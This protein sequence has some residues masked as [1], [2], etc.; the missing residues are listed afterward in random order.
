MAVWCA[1]RLIEQPSTAR[2]LAAGLYAGLAGFLGRN[3]MLYAAAA[4]ALLIAWL[5]WKDRAGGEGRRIGAWVLGLVLGY[6]PMWAMF[7][8]VPGFFHGFWYSNVLVLEHGSNLPSPYP[9]PWLTDWS[10]LRGW[11]LA[12]QAGLS[13]AFL[14]PCLAL[15]IGLVRVLRMRKDEIGA[16]A[17][18]A[19]AF[20]VG[21]CYVHHVSVRSHWSH[22]AEC[23]TPTLLLGLALAASPT[24]PRLRSV[25]WGGIALFSALAFLEVHSLFARFKPGEPQELVACEVDGELLRLPVSKAKQLENLKAFFRARVRPE[26]KVFIAPGRPALYSVLAKVAPTWW[27]YFFWTAT[28]E[29]QRAL[30][31]ELATKGVNWVLVV[32]RSIDGVEERRFAST[33]PLVWQHLASD[34][35]PI[36]AEELGPPN[37]LFRRRDR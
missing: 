34:F 26:E 37:V 33:H 13:A 6:S 17:V 12:C 8:F 23:L 14:L 7:L 9:W 18:L 27:I 19:A 16:N 11:D 4:S 28:D 1:V 32:D 22:L 3:H 30:I 35:T 25:V 29:E 36:A 20:A 2:H 15:P 24:R 31:D 21:L 10:A 5:A